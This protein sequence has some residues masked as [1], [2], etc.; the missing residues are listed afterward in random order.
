MIDK[1]KLEKDII[2]ILIKWN[3]HFP[4]QVSTGET[5]VISTFYKSEIRKMEGIACELTCLNCDSDKWGKML[6]K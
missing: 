4:Y 5:G 6:N 3:V 1:R 2:D